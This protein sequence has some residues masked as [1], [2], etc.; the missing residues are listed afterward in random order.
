MRGWM[1]A[2]CSRHTHLGAYLSAQGITCRLKWAML[3][4]WWYGFG[5]AAVVAGDRGYVLMQLLS[6]CISTYL[7]VGFTVWFAVLTTV[8]Q[9]TGT[10]QVLR[11][12]LYGSSN[13]HLH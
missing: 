1:R 7:D 11:M 12:H 6:S 2:L 4:R 8:W 13:M 9:L 5:A 10:M 3:H